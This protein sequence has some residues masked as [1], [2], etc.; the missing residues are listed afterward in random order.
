MEIDWGVGSY[1]PTGEL[2][3]PVSEA[4]VELAGPLA[5]RTVLDVGC[6]TGNAALAAAARGAVAT[7]VDPASRLLTVARERAAAQNLTVDFLAGDAAS[8]PVGDQSV[9]VV[10]SVF[11]VIFAPD[12]AAAI[13]ELTRV[14][15]PDGRI[16][17]TAW[18]PGGSM[19]VV[20]AA[21][22]K[23]MGEV[24]GQPNTSAS[25]EPSR[26]GTP[27]PL[28]WHDPEALGAAFAPYGFAVEVNRKSLVFESA[29][30][31]EYLERS[32]T[33][34]M[35]VSA[36]RALSQRPDADE[37]R[38]ELWSRLLAAALSVNEDPDGY[39]FTADYT[40]ATARRS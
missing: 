11:G 1:E 27:K 20:N 14:V 21:A 17:V 32:A 5:G 30:A 24:F 8:I 22:A 29:S 16:V 2:L 25:Q 12:A 34:P 6:G 37:L 26:A 33:H 15:A 23:F 36:D 3:A 28:A 18:P 19:S 13:A 38:A 4:V 7:G 9:D 39:R 31:E 40:I 35:A 10:L